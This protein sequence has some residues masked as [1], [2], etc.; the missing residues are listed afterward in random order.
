MEKEF[1][2][3]ETTKNKGVFAFIFGVFMVIIYFAMGIALAFTKIF[4]QLNP[5]ISVVLGIILIIY[6]GFRIFRLIK[7]RKE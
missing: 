5:K 1:S 4:W 3:I 2:S 6:G 7:M